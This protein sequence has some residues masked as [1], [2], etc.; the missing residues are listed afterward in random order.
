MIR[1]YIYGSEL[2]DNEETANRFT[3]LEK[4]ELTVRSSPVY[5][6]YQQNKTF[7]SF[8]YVQR[9]SYDHNNRLELYD[10]DA[11]DYRYEVLKELGHGAFGNVYLCYDH[12]HGMDVAVKVIRNE[13]RFHKQAKIEIELYDLLN[14]VSPYS[15]NIIQ[16]YKAF[17]FRSDLFM[18]F[19]NFGM[20]LYNYYR[21]HDIPEDDVK[22]FGRQIARGIEHLHNLDIIHMDLKPEN[23][24]IRDK[25][26]KIIDLGS[27]M[28][29]E[30]T[31]VLKKNYVQSR[32]YRAPEVLFNTG[33]ST[34]I[35]VWSYGCIIYELLTK[36]PLI[37][38]RSTFDLAIYYIHVLGYPPHD[39]TE[40]YSNPDFFTRKSREL[41]RFRTKK[42]K[43]L[44]PNDFKWHGIENEEFKKFIK[45]NCLNWDPKKR[46]TMSDIISHPYLTS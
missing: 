24:M 23:I 11:I 42:N 46:S 10:N 31:Q 14:T 35:D 45:I 21:K 33:I 36:E 44:Y 43:Y 38:A 39:M 19:Q 9:T 2:L 17:H 41:L 29:K 27:S 34:K 12:K 37:P 26:L 22:A 18:V 5:Y 1:D 4:E 15:D 13:R 30:E 28:I 6:Y 20:N 3:R 16:L 40:I 25:H 32:Y 7:T 8:K